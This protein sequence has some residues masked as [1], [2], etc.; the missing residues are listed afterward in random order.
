MF[1]DMQHGIN[2]ID[3]FVIHFAKNEHVYHFY[4]IALNELLSVY[5]YLLTFCTIFANYQKYFNFRRDECRT[6][7]APILYRAA[8]Y[9]KEWSN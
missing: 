2:V 7:L 9:K 1:Y 5:P 6:Q 4:D 8:R 3:A